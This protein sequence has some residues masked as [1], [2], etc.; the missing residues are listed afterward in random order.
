MHW[1]DRTRALRLD[2]HEPDLEDKTYLV[3]C[4]EDLAPLVESVRWMGIINPPLLQD[5]P[6]RGLVPVLGRR[7]LQAARQA[8]LH[9]V[10]ARTLP[11]EMPESDG[12]RIA[13]WDNLG[14][15][16]SNLAIKAVVVRRLLELFPREVVAKDFL[17]ILEIPPKGPRLER[18][19]TLGGLEFPVLEA[20]AAGRI[21][22]KTATILAG[23]RL[24]DRGLVM[25][26]LE[27]LRLNANTS[28]EVVSNLYD[29]SV[30]EGKPVAELIR[31]KLSQAI[32]FDTEIPARERAA[33]FRQ[34]IRSWKFPQLVAR[35]QEFR[36]W[37]RGL[38]TNNRIEVR[39]APVFES[40]ECT[41]E[42]RVRNRIEAE[43]MVERI[44]GADF[45]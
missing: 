17:P 2:P 30:I 37:L 20:L 39:P 43:N 33:R 8:G 28:A 1:L 41:V 6:H 40:E 18:L 7:R 32:L 27:Q 13:F 16:L 9:E 26:L 38:T 11:S 35:E 36:A 14:Q 15:R 34:L 12:F 25:E 23:L 5:L 42:I 4:F 29:L 22:E 45:Q 44:K 24:Q 21:Q 31:G 19:A 3:P 10:E